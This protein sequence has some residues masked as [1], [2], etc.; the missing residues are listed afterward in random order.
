MNLI[1]SA[2]LLIFINCTIFSLDGSAAV[3]YSTEATAPTQISLDGIL[4]PSPFRQINNRFI[5]EII[6]YEKSQMVPT[7]SIQK[8]ID[9][10]N[11]YFQTNLDVSDELIP[12]FELGNTIYIRI[13]FDEDLVTELPLASIPYVVKS[14]NALRTNRFIDSNKFSIDYSNQRFG[15]G[16]ATPESMLDIVGTVNATG[17]FIGDGSRLFNLRYQGE[18]NYNSL[19]SENGQF[20]IVTVNATGRV[21]IGAPTTIGTPHAHLTTYGSLLLQANSMAT[22]NIF[23]GAGSRWM[24]HGDRDILRIGYTA[25]N[26]WDNDVSGDHSISMGF[27]GVASGKYSIIT[28]GYYNRVVADSS[29]IGGGSEN[30]ILGSDS[31]ISGGQKNLIITSNSVILGGMQNQASQDALVLGGFDNKSYGQGSIVSGFQNVVRGDGAMVLGGNNHELNAPGSIA[32]G[33]KVRV[34]ESHANAVVFGLTDQYSQSAV[35]GSIQIQADNG[36]GLNAV[37]SGNQFAIGGSVVADGFIGDAS[38]IKNIKSPESVWQMLI[39]SLPNHLVF[40]GK[41]GIDRSSLI[42]SLNVS[43]SIHLSGEAVA[44]SGTIRY[45]DDTFEVYKDGQWQTLQMVDTNTTYNATG[46]L[47]LDDQTKTF[48]M[49]SEN[50]IIGQVLKWNGDAWVPSFVDQF[51]EEAHSSRLMNVALSKRLVITS[52]NMLINVPETLS[53]YSLPDNTLSVF[54][55][56]NNQT[57]AY[58]SDLATA[59]EKKL[60]ISVDPPGIHF[61]GVYQN[62]SFLQSQSVG[63]GMEVVNNQFL[64]SLDDAMGNKVDVLKMSSQNILVMG[65]GVSPELPFY[66][67]GRLGSKSLMT[68][69]DESQAGIYLKNEFFRSCSIYDYSSRICYGDQAEDRAVMIEQLNNGNLTI[70]SGPWGK[71]ILF[72]QQDQLFARVQRSYTGETM[73][74]LSSRWL[75]S[76][77]DIK[78]GS[79]HVSDGYGLGF[80]NLGQQRSG[81]VFNSTKPTPIKIYTSGNF[82]TP[83]VSISKDSNVGINVTANA[84]YDLFVRDPGASRERIFQLDAAKNSVNGIEFLVDENNDNSFDSDGETFAMTLSVDDDLD[85]T[86][87]NASVL[88]IQQN[89]MIGFLDDSPSVNLSIKAP[90]TLLNQSGLYFK[91]VDGQT[92][93]PA[94]VMD[95]NELVIDSSNTIDVM[96]AEEN[97]ALEVGKNGVAVNKRQTI[98]QILNQAIGFDVGGSMIVDGDIYNSLDDKIFP[99]DVKN[100]V[101]DNSL[102]MVKRIKINDASGLEFSGQNTA[103]SPLKIAAKPYYNR[104]KLPDGTVFTATGNT[105]LRLVG[106]GITVSANNIVDRSVDGALTFDQIELINDLIS[107]G[108]ISSDL[109]IKGDFVVTEKIKGDASGLRGIPFRW[110]QVTRNSVDIPDPDDAPTDYYDEGEIYYKSGRIGINTNFPTTLLEVVGTSSI[111]EAIASEGITVSNLVGSE[112]IYLRSSHGLGF[113]S[114]KSSVLFGRHGDSLTDPSFERLL[115]IKNDSQ[116]LLGAQSS[117]Y[118]VDIGQSNPF[119]KTSVLFDGATGSSITLGRD[120]SSNIFRVL[121]DDTGTRT[122]VSFV[123]PNLQLQSSSDL[124][125]YV[126]QNK[127]ALKFNDQG[128]LGIFSSKIKNTLDVSGNVSIGFKEKVHSNSLAVNR[129]VGVGLDATTLPIYD[130]EVSGSV[131]VGERY[132]EEIP[133]GVFIN[134][135]G[136]YRLFVGTSNVIQDE[137]VIANGDLSIKN[138]RLTLRNGMDDSL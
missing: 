51:D 90:V 22:S 25:S 30:E 50:V 76:N 99:L 100:D 23:S 115:E 77:I 129:N 137:R 48:H 105:P 34:D 97:V 53:G 87:N 24:W 122:P 5:S 102:R 1:K 12:F 19:S 4:T 134:G 38:L 66:V 89:N 67:G 44:S 47:A 46:A 112:N 121:Y 9:V 2:F 79:V 69:G 41:M 119:D 62:G 10:T 107:G 29:I 61:Q 58:L 7:V 32:F 80:Y 111:N 14:S 98:S 33:Q 3:T 70:Q 92:S 68:F 42:E 133:K 106:K 81:L 15:V 130:L 82:V 65:D 123:N 83:N 63:G 110:E 138:G 43:G 96:T 18:D 78:N 71:D 120:Q 13:Q 55:D 113:N 116:F 109:T 93:Y 128:Q 118:L 8:E 136:S 114:R 108:E 85:L 88:K 73:F 11:N 64:I 54:V 59:D 84:Q 127:Q 75:R 28:G 57:A 49:A 94:M 60:S 39:P 132:S 35:S 131:I 117:S 16:K 103:E 20:N 17:V 26:Y 21:L 125:L 36:V 95:A 56:D 124:L 101:G 72:K 40:D 135:D 31:I 86:R 74:G 126:N 45:F 37:P 6:L 91:E 104:I 52:N 27:S